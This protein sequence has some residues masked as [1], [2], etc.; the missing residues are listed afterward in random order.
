MEIIQQLQRKEGLD[1]ADASALLQFLQEQTTPI[2]SLRN[3]VPTPAVSKQQSSEHLSSFECRYRKQQSPS[4]TVVTRGTVSAKG[5]EKW[6]Q[7]SARRLQG[8]LTL[9]ISSVEGIQPS[10]STRSKDSHGKS[11]NLSSLEEFPP[12]GATR[13]IVGRYVATF[14]ICHVGN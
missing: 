11:F 13:N 12:M 1:T 6:A 2:L 8:S 7:V 5:R 9:D 10:P 3:A 4:A 14:N